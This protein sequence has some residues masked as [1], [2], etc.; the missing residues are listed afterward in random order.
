[1]YGFVNATLIADTREELERKVDSYRKYPF[2][3]CGFIRETTGKFKYR[4]KYM[5][6]V[7]YFNND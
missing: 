4:G 5:V 7:N 1:M 3:E 2:F 6:V